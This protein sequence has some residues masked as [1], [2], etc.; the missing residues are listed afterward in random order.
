M[1][2]FVRGQ[3]WFK[4]VFEKLLN[5]NDQMAQ[6]SVGAERVHE[7]QMAQMPAVDQKEAD[8]EKAK[9]DSDATT[10]QFKKKEVEKNQVSSRHIR[11][12]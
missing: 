1:K 4:S 11:F 6:N 12:W 3:N 5:M 8:L 2:Q 9:E 7:L 10:E